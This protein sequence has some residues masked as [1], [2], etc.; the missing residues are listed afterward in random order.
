MTTALNIPA[1]LTIA[2]RQSPLA[3]WQANFVKDTLEKLYPTMK[4]ELLEMVTKGDKILDTP[5]AKIGGK[6]LFVKELE[7]A[8]Y[9]KRA[10]IAVHSLK[11]VPMVLPEGLTLGAYLERHAPTDAFVSNRYASL[12]ELP[13]GAVLGTSSL[14]R[15]C[16]IAHTKGNL[17]IKSLRGNVGTRLSKLDAGEY[18]AIILATSGLERLGLGERIRHELDDELSLPAVGQGALAIECRAD[19][20]TI[21]QL[22]APLNHL[23][24]RLCVIAERAMNKTL[25]GGCQVPIAGFATI[26]GDTLSLRGRVGSIDGK[27][28]L[29]SQNTITLTHTADDEQNAENLGKQIA[30]DL[31]SQGADQILK[32]VYQNNG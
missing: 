24:T 11:D 28:L 30:Q 21:L 10:D 27:T 19:D 5:L 26:D 25:E 18:D 4:V 14:R 13:D 9:E 8:L 1:T 15:E 31:L 6:G 7:N 12:D 3:L 17:I 32:E 23:A 16:Q 22:L 29:K 2:T 20:E